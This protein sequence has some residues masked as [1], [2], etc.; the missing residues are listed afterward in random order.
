PASLRPSILP[1]VLRSYYQHKIFD[2]ALLSKWYYAGWMHT[3]NSRGGLESDYGFGFEIF[4]NFN[5]LAEAQLIGA[6]WELL[7]SLGL[8]EAVLEINN[9][10]QDACQRTYQDSLK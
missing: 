1:S 6:V 5:H 3:Q 7:Q 2:K 10:G 8:T 9:I 4:G